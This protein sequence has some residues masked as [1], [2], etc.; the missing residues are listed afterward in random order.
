MKIE[1]DYLID[2]IDKI[3]PS[4]VMIVG[5]LILDEFISGE[6]IRLSREAPIPIINKKEH[7]MIPGGAANAANNVV[8]LG[9][10]AYSVGTLGADHSG[11]N[12]SR[13][14]KSLGIN[15]DAAV[16][17]PKNP[18]TTKSRISANS[19]QSVKQQ[20]ARVDTLPSPPLSDDV[21]NSLN[22]SIEKY[23]DQV[24]T[25][26]ISDYNNGV[27][28]DS[29][30]RKSKELALKYNKNLIVDA[31]GDLDRFKGATLLTPNQ[32][33]T[34]AY[35]GFPINSLASL[36][37]AGNYILEKTE[38]KAVLIT[39]G[40]DGMSL[41]ESNG[42]IS[43]IPAFNKRDVFDVTGAG[44]TVVATLSLGI[45]CGLSM[46]DSMLLANLAASIVIRRFGTSTTSL[47]EMKKVLL[48]E[49][50]I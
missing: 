32:P 26:L 45:A 13:V 35:V 16:I 43:N 17:D 22:L 30:I 34:E 23:I 31:Q 48:T 41:F 8:S 42:E 29:S 40:S 20:V 1:R 49:K 15:L 46:K 33:D 37:K 7:Q 18:T 3:N 44:D 36:E 14:M 39:R 5:D 10:K 6:V 19:R 9:G 50:I 2:L 27:I 47:E 11:E 4:G 24:E 21:I 38:A 28:C 25:I 12:L